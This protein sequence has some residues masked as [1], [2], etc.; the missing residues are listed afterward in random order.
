MPVGSC[1]RKT[2]QSRS[3]FARRP[4]YERDGG[5]CLAADRGLVAAPYPNFPGR[6]NS[7]TKRVVFEGLLRYPASCGLEAVVSV[8]IDLLDRYPQQ[9][10]AAFDSANR[11]VHDEDGH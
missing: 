5:G 10:P 7:P 3:G 8:R 4:W 2:T 11:F 9:E 1:P 6:I